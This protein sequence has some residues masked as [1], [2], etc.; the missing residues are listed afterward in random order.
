[1]EDNGWIILAQDRENRQAALGI[2]MNL[3]LTI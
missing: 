3:F 1:M 2:V